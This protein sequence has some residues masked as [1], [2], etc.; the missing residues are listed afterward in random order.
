MGS[1]EARNLLTV[2]W[3]PS[4]KVGYSPG[5]T[6]ALQVPE[7]DR[8]GL[9]ASTPPSGSLLPLRVPCFLGTS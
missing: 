5:L 2:T 7:R 6:P 3:V 1:P 4:G 9:E 8:L